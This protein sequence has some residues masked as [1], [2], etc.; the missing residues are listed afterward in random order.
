MMAAAAVD[1][2]GG[3]QR[4]RMTMARK[5]GWQTKMEKDESRQRETAETAEWQ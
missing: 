2:V 4:Q 1:G 3:R 5:I